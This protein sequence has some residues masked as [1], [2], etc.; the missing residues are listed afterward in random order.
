MWQLSVGFMLPMSALHAQG[1]QHASEAMEIGA[2]ADPAPCHGEGK[3]A[4]VHHESA[5]AGVPPCCQSHG[6]LGDCFVMCALPT[7]IATVHLTVRTEDS[8]AALR[9]GMVPPPMV[10][11]FRPPI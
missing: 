3:V 2:N 6:C 9:A 11:F 1:M 5:P 10:E 8:S 7:V 4:E